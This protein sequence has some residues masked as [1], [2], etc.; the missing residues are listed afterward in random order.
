MLYIKIGNE[1]YPAKFHTFRT[2][3]NK[4]GIRVIGEVPTANGFLI[5]DDND[6]VVFDRSEYTY[7][8]REDDT[9]KEYTKEYEEIIPTES[10][11]LGT[12]DNPF[13]ALSRQISAVNS[14]VTEIT[15]YEQTKMG[16]Y[17]EIEKNFY[18]VPDGVLTVVFDNYDGQY[19]ISRVADRV[20]I[21][22]PRLENNTN[23]T[24]TVQ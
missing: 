23:I 16:Y 2:Q 8:Y 24:I 9:C 21:G 19:E 3:A 4:E 7:L 12:P 18:G 10:F 5:V 17:G 15:P 22:F 6:E 11:A 13:S 14:R 20:S 1:K